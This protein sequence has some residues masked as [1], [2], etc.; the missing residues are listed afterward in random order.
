M[1]I[2]EAIVESGSG[3]TGRNRNEKLK[4]SNHVE[5]LVKMIVRQSF[6]KP[7]ERRGNFSDFNLTE[8]I[9]KMVGARS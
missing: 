8:F 6:R 2:N 7:E 9:V 3:N 5:A 1:F 4:N